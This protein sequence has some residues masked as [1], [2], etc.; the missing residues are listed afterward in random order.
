MMQPEILIV[1]DQAIIA[2]AIAADLEKNGYRVKEICETGESA[3]LSVESSL[4]DLVIMDIKLQGELDGIQVTE[5][6]LKKYRVPVIYLTDLK[7]ERT[8]QQAKLTAP[9]HYLTKPFQAH[10]LIMAVEL[11]I[12]NGATT[13]MGNK[14]G[15]FKEKDQAIKVVYEDILY[16]KSD[17]AYCEIV[18]QKDKFTVSQPLKIVQKKIPYPDLVRISRSYCINK[19]HVDRIIGQTIIINDVRVAVGET[20]SEVFKQHFNII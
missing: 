5:R 3:L 10:Q 8:F 9:S 15:F 6:I 20:Y 2:E 13:S 19:N 14:F 4:P 18:T 12:F 7:D 1:E 17:R 11:A 16:L